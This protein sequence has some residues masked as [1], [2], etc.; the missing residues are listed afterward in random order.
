MKYIK[1]LAIP[2]NPFSTI[3]CQYTSSFWAVGLLE[4]VCQ[5]SGGCVFQSFAILH[6]IL[7]STEALGP[8]G[9]YA[10]G[11]SDHHFKGVSQELF[12][13]IAAEATKAATKAAMDAVAEFL[14]KRERRDNL[15]IIERER[16]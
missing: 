5:D 1:Q 6:A 3:Y 10:Y 12:M 7:H 11:G 16:E 15:V 13:K 2:L 9:K 4:L 8:G 14:E